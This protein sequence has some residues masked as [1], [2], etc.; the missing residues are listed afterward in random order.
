M[1][2]KETQKNRQAWMLFILIVVG[3]IEIGTFGYGFFKQVING[4]Q[5]GENPTSDTMLTILFVFM[6]TLCLTLFI[7]FFVAK[8][9][10][11]IDRNAIE[12]RFFPYHFRSH[13][14][15]WDTVES[16]KVITYNPLRDYGGWGIS[17]GFG[18]KKAFS[19]AG[20]KGL[21]LYLKNGKRILIG[22]QKENELRDFLTKLNINTGANS[23]IPAS[24]VSLLR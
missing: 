9:T 8:L 16:Y 22:T 1:T 7:L 12:Y 24:R 19:V 18:N 2:F 6:T 21:Q 13:K 14:I 20:D 23:K 5:F 3:A 4:Q 17:S 15:I 10:T 11:V